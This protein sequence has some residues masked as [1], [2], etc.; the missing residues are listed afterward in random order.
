MAGKAGAA[1][2]TVT[3]GLGDSLRALVSAMTAPDATPIAS[4]LMQLQAQMLTVLHKATGASGAQKP[5]MGGAPPG[6]PPGAG[7]PPPGGPAPGALGGG[8]GGTNLAQLQGG[9][10][11]GPSG[12]ARSSVS[13][14]MLRQLAASSADDDGG[15]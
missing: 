6:G 11:A 10:G 7:G 2:T 15:T 3:E 8:P 9:G 1:P 5:P 4:E 13:P 12:A 14:D